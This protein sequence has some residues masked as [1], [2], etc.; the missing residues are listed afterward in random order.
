M[1]PNAERRPGR[2]GGVQEMHSDGGISTIVSDPVRL[3]HALAELLELSGER[4]AWLARLGDEY[5]LGYKL[6]Y[7]DGARDGY[8]RGA[9]LLE[10]T[11]PAIVRQLGGPSLAELELLRWGPGGREHF[12]DP[13]PGDR[14]GQE[15]AA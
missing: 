1:T 3:A 8:E 13:R 6:G 4:D 7:A 11:W 2:R 5:R 14:N 15:H 10:A 9:R 12:G